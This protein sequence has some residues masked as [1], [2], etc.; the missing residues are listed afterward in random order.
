MKTIDM[1]GMKVG[2]LSVVKAAEAA[3]G[4]A[5][6]LCICD[7]GVEKAV[8]GKHLRSGQV[9]SCGCKKSEIRKTDEEKLASRREYLAQNRDSSAAAQKRYRERNLEAMNAANRSRQAIYRQQNA[10][11]S[12]LESVSNTDAF[13]SR[14]GIG[15]ENEC[16]NWLGAKG[17]KGYGLYSPLPGITLR[18][19]RVAYAL[20]NSG[21]EDSK[22][23]CHHC[24]N[25]SCCNPLHL[26]LGTPKDNVD[27]MVQKGRNLSPRGESN[28][29]ARLTS[30]QACLIFQDRRTN[31]EVSGQ[32][33]ISSSLVSMIRKRK[34]WAE[35]T[36]SL[37]EQPPRKTGPKP[38]LSN[39]ELQGITA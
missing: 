2:R 10:G 9:V 33:G 15:A 11:L 34:I 19:H 24:D 29:M 13:W 3:K 20:H 6:W 4:R 37:P 38:R 39:S 17:D 31:K 23:V 36:S 26:F 35:A 14:V 8:S 30:A 25:P 28:G 5:V 12:L 27:D 1:T 21:I 22:F 18:A 16:W 32:Y 7:C